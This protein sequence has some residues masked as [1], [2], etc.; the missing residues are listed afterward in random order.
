MKRFLLK[1]SLF[2]VILAGI[3][4]IME[5]GFRLKPNPFRD[6][7]DGLDKYASEI[8]ILALGHSHANEGIDPHVMKRRAFNMAIGFQNV[9]FVD[10]ILNLISYIFQLVHQYQFSILENN[11][12]IHLFHFLQLFQI[13]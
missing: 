11:L 10:Y 9:Y 5:V 12:K 3:L 8:E 2:V 13:V 7:Y 4:T 1:L 6:K